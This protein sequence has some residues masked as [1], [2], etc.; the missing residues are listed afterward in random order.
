[1]E[2][3]ADDT[4]GEIIFLINIRM[5]RDLRGIGVIGPR[6]CLRVRHRSYVYDEV[7]WQEARSNP[8]GDCKVV[9]ASEL[10]G[11]EVTWEL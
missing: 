7:C 2:N 6:C 3:C 4:S 9:K 5:A 10:G 8:E 11:K 1:M